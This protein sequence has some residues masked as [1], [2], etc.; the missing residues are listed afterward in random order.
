MFTNIWTRF[1][2][3]SVA[4]NSDVSATKTKEQAP[5]GVQKETDDPAAQPKKPAVCNIL[6]LGKTG[7]GKTS[8]L[9][10]LYGFTLPVGVAENRK[11]PA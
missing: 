5:D 2:Q 10:Y 9:N 4:K 11:R 3:K 1:K 6:A 7:S 8:L